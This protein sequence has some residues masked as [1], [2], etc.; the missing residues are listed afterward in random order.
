M[1]PFYIHILAS[2]TLLS[3]TNSN[4]NELAEQIFRALKPQEA[5]VLVQINHECFY[6]EESRFIGNIN[7]GSSYSDINVIDQY[8]GN[9]QLQMAKKNWLQSDEMIFKV[10]PNTSMDY[11]NYG[12][13]LIGRKNADNLEGYILSRASYKWAVLNKQRAILKFEGYIVRP[14]D[15]IIPENEIPLSGTIYFKKPHIDLNDLDAKALERN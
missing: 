5:Y 2:L 8:G 15:A 12:S 13:M 14:Q 11:P 7:L 1:R 3:C 6:P 4:E 9:I 10:S